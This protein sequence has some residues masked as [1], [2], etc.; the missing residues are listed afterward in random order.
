MKKSLIVA[1]LLLVGGS[2]LVAAEGSGWYTG[3]EAGNTK[4]DFSMSALGVS[5]SGDTDGSSATL[6]VGYYFDANQRASTWY[7]KIKKADG[8]DKAEAYGL[9]YDYLFGTSAFKPFLGAVV[10][11]QSYKEAELKLNGLVYGAQAGLNYAMTSNLSAEIGYR[12]LISNADDN[13]VVLGIP[14]KVEADKI[15][16]W[17]VGLNY[18][19]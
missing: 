13:I 11:Y 3:I 6:K 17:Y 7:H 18:K 9:N 10:G 12:Y 19:F 14:V 1:S 4:M 5:S 8:V 15:K 16:T 2:A